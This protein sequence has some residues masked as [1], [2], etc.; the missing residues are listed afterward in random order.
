MNEIMKSV[1][2][3][4]SV[5]LACLDDWKNYVLSNKEKIAQE[6]KLIDADYNADDYL[7]DEYRNKIMN[8]GSAHGGY[9]ERNKGYQLKLDQL[10]WVGEDQA[11]RLKHIANYRTLNETMGFNLGIKHNALCIAYPEQGFI[12]WHNNAN[13]SSYN[14]IFTYSETGDGYWEHFNPY[15]E[16]VER[17]NDV[18]GWQVKAS[19]FGAYS[20]NNKNSLVYHSAKTN[21]CWR[22]TVS[23]IF[24]R[25][26][27][28]WWE[29][30]IEEVEND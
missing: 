16:Q 22:M 5:L 28:E 12:G 29:Q 27:K 13:A 11:F 30:A 8:M 1:T 24:G 6:I 14:I 23:Y 9:P 10:K 20:E 18:P 25:E 17:I 21:D 26:N 19:Y 15:T 2:L 3:R 7:S 4:N